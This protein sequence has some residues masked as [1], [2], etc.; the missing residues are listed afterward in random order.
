MESIGLEL[1]FTHVSASDARAAADVLRQY[2]SSVG[3]VDLF[4]TMV[5][6]SNASIVIA[7]LQHCTRLS[8]LNPGV[9][10]NAA[11][12]Q[13]VAKVI[14]KNKT[15]L[16]GLTVPAGDEDLPLIAPSITTCRQ[17][18]SLTI[19]SRALTNKSAPAIADVDT[20]RC[21]RSLKHFGLIGRIDVDGFTPIASSLLDTSAQ[22]DRLALH[23]TM[24]SVPM[25]SNILTSLTCFKTLQLV[26]KHDRR[27]R[28]SATYQTSEANDIT[29]IPLLI[30]VDLTIQP[31]E[32]DGY[33][34]AAQ[35][36]SAG[37]DPGVE[38][39]KYISSDR[40]GC[41]RH[42]SA[43]LHDVGVQGETKWTALHRWLTGHRAASAR[44]RQW[45]LAADRSSLLLLTLFSDHK[46]PTSF[47]AIINLW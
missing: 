29:A 8:Y 24:L 4:S 38:Q 31:G 18:V 43:D 16:R 44:F 20:L 45:S 22:L 40:P 35:T 10:S 2:C 39:E 9:T 33:A 13:I 5:N 11:G 28:F 1:T 41:R 23:W 12:S 26:W 6:D 37:G 17:L 36:N 7:G 19:G 21:H 25:L 46:S 27:R 34:A 30:D 47:N 3:K 15:S 14:E 32:D 42:R